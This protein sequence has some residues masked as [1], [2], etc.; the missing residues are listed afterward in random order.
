MEELRQLLVPEAA[1]QMIVDHPDSLHEGIA[2]GW[3][4]KTEAPLQQIFAHGVG[5]GG[6][7]GKALGPFVDLRTASGELPDVAIKAA[8]LFLHSEKRLRIRNG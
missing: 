5:F 6:P 7:R 4:Y 1:H 2:D 3:S 8:E